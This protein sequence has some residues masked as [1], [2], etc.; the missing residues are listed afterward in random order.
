MSNLPHHAAFFLVLLLCGACVQGPEVSAI[1][2]AGPSKL[3][4]DSSEVP[5]AVRAIE[6]LI[7]AE[8]ALIA[9][10]IE[11]TCSCNYEW[12]I[13][14]SGEDVV[15]LR[16]EGDG[17]IS[18]A[19]GKA[20][21]NFRN[22]QLRASRRIVFKKSGFDV[23]PFIRIVARGRAAYASD[24]GVLRGAQIRVD[25]AQLSVDGLPVATVSPRPVAAQEYR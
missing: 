21:A 7:E 13:S 19:R 3:R 4:H 16:A 15:P 22:L 11:I 20:R 25:N 18:E 9:D 24:T 1:A 5:A 8:G 14:L 2:T 12:D 6:V 17:H 10:E 23:Q